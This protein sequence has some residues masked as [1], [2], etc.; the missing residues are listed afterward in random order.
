MFPEE[1]QRPGRCLRSSHS[2]RI[3]SSMWL[4]SELVL[5]QVQPQETMITV[6]HASHAEPWSEVRVGCGFGGT[7][8]GSKI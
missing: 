1:P 3:V 8:M 4:L 7:T 5:R 6:W 2:G